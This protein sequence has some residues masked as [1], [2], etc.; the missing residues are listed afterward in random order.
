MVQIRRGVLFCLLVACSLVTVG[1]ESPDLRISLPPVMACLPIA[2]A[3]HWG[4]F[5]EHGVSVELIG[6]TDNQQRSDALSTGNLNAVL[7]DVTQ[8]IWDCQEGHDLVVT[9]AAHVRTQTGSVHVALVSPTSFN[10]RSM[11]ELLSS[12]SKLYCLYRSDHEY[13][14][15]RL[16]DSQMDRASWGGTCYFTDALS[17]AVWFAARSL[18]S[19]VLPEPYIAYIRTYHPQG[20]KP[21]DVTMLS[22]FSGVD[23]L[24]TLVVFRRAFV[25]QYPDV[26][27]G[28]YAAYLAA[29][30]RINETPREQIVNV[31]IDVALSLFFQAA[32]PE[33]I[34][35]DV[36]DAIPFPQFELPTFLLREQYDDV[37]SWMLKKG[38]AAALP[39]YD[40]VADFHF[41]P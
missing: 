15:D 23:I 4:L 19:A 33:L 17:L 20:G 25:E 2:F 13:M 28:F 29:I 5:E 11:D 9:S 14:L 21:I 30:E 22:D 26:V 31:G 37:G 6:M 10:I 1:K 7:E 41:L 3:E 18:P 40:S 16:L 27:E 36:I 35:Q 38:Y 32:D 39:N 8:F 24:P 12:E 34:G